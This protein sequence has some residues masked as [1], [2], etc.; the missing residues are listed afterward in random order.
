MGSADM[1]LAIQDAEC[2]SGRQ[3]SQGK[4]PIHIVHTMKVMHCLLSLSQ[5]SAMA[6]TALFKERTTR[7]STVSKREEERTQALYIKL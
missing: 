2:T 6:Q 5:V 7:V 3:L 4:H 1:P